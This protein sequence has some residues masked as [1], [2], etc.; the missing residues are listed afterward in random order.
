MADDQ[1]NNE[2]IFPKGEEVKPYSGLPKSYRY[3]LLGFMMPQL[4]SSVQGMEGNIDDYTQNALG[5]YNQQFNQYIGNEIPKQVR[6][7]AKRGVLSS[8]VAENTLSQTYSD[9]ARKSS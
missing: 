3:Q 7:L 4:Q 1:F 8:S 9:A 2:M 5:T 6:D